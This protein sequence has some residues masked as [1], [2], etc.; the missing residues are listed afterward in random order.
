MIRNP[1]PPVPRFSVTRCSVTPPSM[2][3][4]EIMRCY[5]L[6]IIVNFYYI[7]FNNVYDSK[8]KLVLDKDR[9]LKH[10]YF[11]VAQHFEGNTLIAKKRARKTVRY[12]NNYLL[13]IPSNYP[14]P[15]VRLYGSFQRF[16]SVSCSRHLRVI[17]FFI[18]RCYVLATHFSVCRD[19]SHTRT[20]FDNEFLFGLISSIQTSHRFR[21]LGR[22]VPATSEWYRH[23]FHDRKY[24]GTLYL[25]TGCLP[26]RTT[27]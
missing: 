8:L 7:L 23:A 27:L 26:F 2:S 3:L 19:H 16:I 21:A 18:R 17:S 1:N 13:F 9:V 24:P 25:E 10:C 12:L 4:R 14:L 11:I 5:K 15:C 20:R 22:V 6:K